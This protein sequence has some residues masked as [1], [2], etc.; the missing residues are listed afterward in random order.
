MAESKSSVYGALAANTG[1]AVLKFVAASISGS[2]AML[3]EA[4]HSTVDAGNGLLI[5]LGISRSKRPADDQHPFGHGKEVYFWS[6]IVSILIFG[7]GGGMSIYEGIEHLR[8]PEELGNPFWNYMVLGGAF[9]FEGASFVLAIRNFNKEKG[10]GSFWTE[11]R[12]SKD[13]ASFAVIYEDAAALLGLIIAFLGVFLG[14]YFN[15]LLFDGAASL[16]IGLVLA[17][18][19]IIMVIE[20]RDLLIGESAR[21]EM[22]DGICNLV[23]ADPDVQHV[24]RPLTMQMAP[25]EILL[26]LDVQ[27]KEI[28]GIQVT[29]VIS[30]LEGNIRTQFPDIKRIYIE[31]RN[32]AVV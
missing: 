23:L 14:H 6:L 4:I 15:N 2:S 19:A 18:V 31:A 3:S 22:I 7:L 28:S 25:N 32:L 8:H 21:S 13:P 16:I 12:K 24:R 20:S 1:I 9:L 29:K 26:A 17:F 11:L 30:R 5:L 10:N 27:F